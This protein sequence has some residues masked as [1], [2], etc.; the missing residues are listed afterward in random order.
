MLYANSLSFY[1]VHPSVRIYLRTADRIVNDIIC[2]IKILKRKQY[3]IC[4]N[5]ITVFMIHNIFMI[6]IW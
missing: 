1:Q 3:E 6:S 4:I 2:I 5:I